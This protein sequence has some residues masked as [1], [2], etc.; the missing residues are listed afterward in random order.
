MGNAAGDPRLEQQLTDLFRETGE[1]H[2]EAFIKTEGEDPE[3]PLW[4][5]DYV[6]EPLREL[7]GAALTRSQLV[8]LLI[9]ASS[10]QQVKAPGADWARYYA[11][12]FQERYR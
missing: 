6:L 2:H 4:Y 3:W 9:T 1:A 5:A 10:E 11:R 8:H 12:F 7:L